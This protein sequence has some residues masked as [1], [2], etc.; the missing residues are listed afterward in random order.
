MHL[1]LSL[2]HLDLI[3]QLY[4]HF[5][6]Y[7]DKNAQDIELEFERDFMSTIII[8]NHLKEVI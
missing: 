2:K 6:Y 1:I 4:D 3:E 5:N 7:E 8:Y